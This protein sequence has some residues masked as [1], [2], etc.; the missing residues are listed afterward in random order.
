M[1]GEIK[2]AHADMETTSARENAAHEEDKARIMA[3]FHEEKQE[4]QHQLDA[5]IESY[6]AL[7]KVL[8]FLALWI[9]IC[10]F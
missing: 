2:V 5:Q 4:I 6:K 9:R 1:I 7:D 8:L 3:Q 10:V